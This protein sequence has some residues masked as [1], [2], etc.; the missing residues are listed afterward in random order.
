[1]RKTPAIFATRRYMPVRQGL[2][3]AALCLSASAARAFPEYQ[4]YIVKHSG[5]PVNCAFCHTHADGPQGAAPGQ[6][7]RLTP[8]ELEALGRGRAALEPGVDVDNP[9]LNAFG[10][11]IVKSVGMR[12]LAELKLA[13]EQLAAALPPESDL[14]AD[15]VS[16]AQEYQD[17]TH[18][19][20]H[21]DGRPWLLFRHNFQ[22]N[23]AQIV[24]TLAATMLG[25]YGLRH[26]LEGFDVATRAH[27]ED[28]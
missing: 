23:L 24:L 27:V 16:D 15:G 10:D 21:T 13:P 26:L 9:V 17:G 8:Q 4:R 3:I 25:L 12:R 5:R 1:M 19:L 20:L 2:L 18:P 11:H 7:G 28:E 6:I 14:D 22:R